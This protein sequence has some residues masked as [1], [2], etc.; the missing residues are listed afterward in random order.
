MLVQRDPV[1]PLAGPA[2]PAPA[3]PGPARPGPARTR[4]AAAGPARALQVLDRELVRNRA[5]QPAAQ[6]GEG[7][8]LVGAARHGEGLRGVH[9]EHAGALESAVD[10]GQTARA[11]A[12]ERLDLVRI[13][14]GAIVDHERGGARGGRGSL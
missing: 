1:Q 3:A 13:E 6:A 8:V 5:A 12:E 4:P 14:A 10:A 11:G 9:V 2:P 7:E